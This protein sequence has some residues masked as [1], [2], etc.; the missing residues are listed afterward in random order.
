MKGGIR[1]FSEP[2]GNRIVASQIKRERREKTK[3]IK[4]KIN[5]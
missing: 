1:A 3:K 4:Q 5:K 2:I